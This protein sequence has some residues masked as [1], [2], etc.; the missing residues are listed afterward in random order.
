[1]NYCWLDR[2]TEGIF[3]VTTGQEFVN[4]WRSSCFTEKRTDCDLWTVSK[5][6]T[7]RQDRCFNLVVN[8]RLAVASWVFW[9]VLVIAD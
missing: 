2:H 9:V 6:R 1:M 3:H 7:L 8:S 4:I 5:T